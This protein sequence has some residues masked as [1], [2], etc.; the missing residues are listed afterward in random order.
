VVSHGRSIVPIQRR[1]RRTGPVAPLQPRRRRS[2]PQQ[3]PA[4]FAP[5]AYATEA[6]P[7]APRAGDAHHRYIAS[8][9]DPR[10]PGRNRTHTLG[11]ARLY[12]LLLVNG[13]ANGVDLVRE[14]FVD[15]SAAIGRTRCTQRL[16]SNRGKIPDSGGDPLGTSVVSASALKKRGPGL[17][18]VRCLGRPNVS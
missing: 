14:R 5:T 11:S 12:P 8:G 15:S 16:Q 18:D 10:T 9:A 4:A 6:F 17:C 1:H 2:R 13:F 7:D 3:P